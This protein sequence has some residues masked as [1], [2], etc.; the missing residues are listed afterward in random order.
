MS[1]S[2]VQNFSILKAACSDAPFALCRLP[3]EAEWRVFAGGTY[4]G[5]SLHFDGLDVDSWLC[6]PCGDMPVASQSTPRAAYQSGVEAVVANLRRRGGKTVLCRQVCGTFDRFDPD[7][8]ARAYFDDFPDMFCYLFYHPATG[9]WMGASPELLLS[10]DA[11]GIGHTRALAGTRPAEAGP[12][13]A[14][15]IDEHRMVVED[16]CTRAASVPGCEPVVG[17]CGTLR[18]GSIEHLATPIDLY[19]PG[20]VEM[21]PV[22]EAIHPTAAVCGM[23]ASVAAAE[24]DSTEPFRRNFYGGAIIAGDVAYVVLR[25][26]HFDRERWC[27]Y[28]GSGITARSVAAD[29]WRETQAKAAPLVNLLNSY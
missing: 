5:V 11:D 1:K 15:N 19:R 4:D 23:P 13:D 2:Q 22:V 10:I 21:R 14:K 3:G 29:E 28:T 8:M 20:G 7:A 27:V 24:I 6:R 9:Y 17:R 25:C 16:I 26:V 12:W 18:Y